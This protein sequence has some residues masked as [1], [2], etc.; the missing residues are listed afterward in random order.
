MI[1]SIA[2]QHFLN[3]IIY[4]SVLI[5][6]KENHFLNDIIHVFLLWENRLKT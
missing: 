2:C 1:V 6:L 5:L 4:E 3:N